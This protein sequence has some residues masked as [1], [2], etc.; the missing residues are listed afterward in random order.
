MDSARSTDSRFPTE[1]ISPRVSALK[2]S[3]TLAINE[4]AKRLLAAGQDIV[5]L[6]FGQSPFPVPRTVVESLQKHAAA[7][8][9]LPV[10][11]LPALREEI[12]RF[13]R[14]RGD[15]VSSDDIIIGPGSKELLYH[16]ILALGRPVLLP[17]PSWVTYQPQ[18]LL[19]ES[20]WHWIDTGPNAWKLLPEQLDHYCKL[21][22]EPA[23]LV[24]NAPSN[25]TGV[26]YS[27]DE[28][29]AL[30]EVA[31]KHNLII[32]AD[33]IYHALHFEKAPGSLLQYYTEGT[34][35]T[36]GLS[37]WCGA[38]GWRLGY[39]IVPM[40]SLKR[41]MLAIA[42]ETFTSV[43]TPI[44]HA[45]ITAFR[46]EENIAQ[47]VRTAS[48]ILKKVSSYCASYLRE[49]DVGVV[50]PSAGFYL[51]PDFAAYHKALRA[52]GLSGNIDLCD[53][54]LEEVGVALLPGSAFGRPENEWTAR[55]AFV[56]FDGEKALQQPRQ[57]VNDLAPRIVEGIGRICNWLKQH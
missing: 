48:A 39:A 43:S 51:M 55:L 50:E 21:S 6:G 40:P 23:L 36:S 3:P 41:G 27:D 52:R 32:L 19:A 8:D 29:P 22:R 33:E 13:H 44:Q 28:L 47:Y 57:G 34:V 7:K 38:G 49:Y 25:P 5:H 56:D 45:A 46:F 30:A 20:Q 54:L 10:Q 42:S 15:A 53:A 24:L 12:A 1:I 18:A 16:V 4:K 11:G 35:I 31:R 17:S 26:T 37:K 2:P 14:R 9:Y